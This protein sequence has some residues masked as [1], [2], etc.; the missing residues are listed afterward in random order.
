MTEFTASYDRTTKIISAGVCAVLLLAGFLT[1]NILV[2]CLSALVVML[3]YA[4]SPRGY[5]LLERS[6]VVKRFLGG[7]RMPLGR[8]REARRTT[9]DDLGGCIR[10]RLHSS[11]HGSILLAG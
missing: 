9:S 4:Y 7:A 8:V 3:S 2:V 5:A 6:I 10:F 1:H 11:H